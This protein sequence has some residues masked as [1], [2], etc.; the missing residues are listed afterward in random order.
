MQRKHTKKTDYVRFYCTGRNVKIISITS[1]KRV[2]DS[3]KGCIIG[4]NKIISPL[5]KTLDSHINCPVGGAL[6]NK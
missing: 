6:S 5:E 2:K 1:G 3:Q 4:R